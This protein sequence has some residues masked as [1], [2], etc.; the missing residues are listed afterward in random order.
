MRWLPAFLLLVLGAAFAQVENYEGFEDPEQNARYRELI[1]SIRCMKCQ[2]QSIAEA[3]V[4]VAA[5]LRREVREMMAEGKTD[6]EIRDFLAARYGDFINFLPPFKPST[7]LLW[8]AP[9]LLLL[10]GG[11]IFARVLRTR[12]RMPLSEDIE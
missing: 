12:M 11:V 7:W 10:G 6:S 2:N 4:D 9:V 8:S 1:H 3:P 5:D